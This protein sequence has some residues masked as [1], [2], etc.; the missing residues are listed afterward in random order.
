MAQE[1]T[2][3]IIAEGKNIKLVTGQVDKL[4]KE[5]KNTGNSMKNAGKQ[6]DQFFNKQQ[7]G[8][9]GVANGTKSF[10]KMQ[11]TIGSGSSGLVGAYATLAANV[12]AATAMFNA[13][14][15]AARFDALTQG[16]EAMGNQSGATLSVMARGLKEITEGAISTEE[17][18][19]SAAL[20]ASGGFGAKE[21]GGLAKIAK[22]ASL[23]LGR[24]LGDA[25]DRL[26]RGAIKLEPEIL[27]ELGIMVRLDD[28]V[29]KYAA[30]LGKS[31]SSLTQMERRQAFMNEI[32]VQ[33]EQK[34]GGIANAVDTNPYD[35]LAGALADLSEK[36]LSFINNSGVT[37][38]IEIL[39]KNMFALAGA[40]TLV[41]STFAKQ[42]L[43]VL[44]EGGS[45]ALATAK[46]LKIASRAAAEQAK[47][48]VAGKRAALSDK[49]GGKVYK[50]LVKDLK[51]GT[52]STKEFEQAKK[53][54]RA[55]E[56]RLQSQLDSGRINGKKSRELKAGE[57]KD[58]LDLI[59]LTKQEIVAVQQLQLAQQGQGAAF[60]ASKTASAGARAQGTASGLLGEMSGKTGL[61]GIKAL[62][63]MLGKASKSARRFKLELMSANKVTSATGRVHI[64][65]LAKGLA[66]VKGF[67]FQAGLSAKLFGAAL[68]NAIPVIG[69]VIF[70]AGLIG[71]AISNAMKTP[72]TEALKKAQEN[73]RDV[74]DSLP[75]KVEAF[76]RAQ[77]LLSNPA[78]R[79]TQ[80]YSILSGTIDEAVKTMDDLLKKEKEVAKAEER[81]KNAKAEFSGFSGGAETDLGDL[82]GR[83]SA[84]G[85]AGQMTSFYEQEFSG[86]LKATNRFS[87]AQLDILGGLVNK[88]QFN[89]FSEIM[90]SG[91]FPDLEKDFDLAGLVA[92]GTSTEDI[93]NKMSEALRNTQ[94]SAKGVGPALVGLAEAFKT[95][96]IAFSKFFQTGVKKTPYDQIKKNMQEV[97]NNIN[98][99]RE[100]LGNEKTP[101]GQFK[102]MQM[103][104]AIGVGAALTGAGSMVGTVLGPEFRAAQDRAIKNGEIR[105]K[106]AAEL[107]VLESKEGDITKEV[108]DL[109]GKIAVATG[110]QENAEFAL[111]K[112]YTKNAQG[113]LTQL[114]ILQEQGL[115]TANIVKKEESRAKLLKATIMTGAA[116]GIQIDFQNNALEKQNDYLTNQITFWTTIAAKEPEGTERRAQLD[117]FI[118]GLQQKQQK[119]KENIMSVEERSFQ[120]T[121]ASLAIRTKELAAEKAIA[122]LLRQ[123]T[124]DMAIINEFE[125]QGMKDPLTKFKA[126]VQAAKD[127]KKF[128]VEEAN[129]KM[130]TLQAE[131]DVIK[132]R[133][134]LLALELEKEG[135]NDLAKKVRDSAG[136]LD[137][138]T[139]RQREVLQ[140]TADMAGIT[141]QASIIKSFQGALSES[142]TSQAIG[143]LAEVTGARASN[144]YDKAVKLAG[145]KAYDEA[146]AAGVSESTSQVLRD[147]AE[148]GAKDPGGAADKA[149][150][151]AGKLTG[152]DVFQGIQGG[153][154]ELAKLG[155][156]GELVQTA[157]NG[158][159]NIGVAFKALGESGGSAASK[160]A[161]GMAIVSE[162]SNIMAAH[163]K[164]KIAN[165]DREIEAE[166]KRDGKSKASLD[167]IKAMEKKKEQMARKAFEMSKK[168]QIASAIINT[169]GAV[170]G[171]LNYDPK[172]V[173]NIPLAIAVG[174]MGMAQIAM[175]Q[176]TSFQGSSSGGGAAAPQSI[177][178]GKR[179]TS[180]DVSKGATG[181]E[182]AFLRGERGIGSNANAF[183][184]GGAAGMRK[185]YAAGGEIMVGEKGPEILQPTS[186]GFNVIPNDKMGG[187]TTN[188]NFTINAV[189]AAGV[190]EVL[191]AQRAN[192][193]NM[194]REAAHEHGEE[195]I[196][197]VNTSSYGGG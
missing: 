73:L 41:A 43:P 131:T 87:E 129:I 102:E 176:K 145:D 123:Q 99:V 107:I 22:G 5:V 57:K 53:S 52:A 108:A 64:P 140:K 112:H 27:D 197:G 133:Y 20:G 16:L 61:G 115:T 181:G 72:E 144:A 183:T 62:P 91:L 106:L 121:K 187:G 75:G 168:M 172:G 71:G 81:K 119:N 167:K 195:F 54:L 174:A 147:N 182:P 186:N 169:A 152:A 171:A 134:E 193:I 179:N 69:Q 117:A 166:K 80:S 110:N 92:A 153:L 130:L 143:M 40:A 28:A 136:A 21:L 44:A 114:E 173:W 83:G 19:R 196:E 84:F 103:E 98:K 10:S 125:L 1:L 7:K 127:K 90:R 165:I 170:I 137:A 34:F 78:L 159:V 122:G 128:A 18:F 139:A 155:P 126:E 154:A 96:D 70:F 12:F 17:A 111:G 48:E 89:T 120:V 180:V 32:L 23:A 146:I 9:I 85:N 138:A 132:A 124:A 189:D 37:A 3:K 93:L 67:F 95:A 100:E 8:V 65:K 56:A 55:T 24:D 4:G 33:G 104:T 46:N 142:N 79:I 31:A 150:T 30:T 175:I 86:V 88:P 185:G 109:K 11:Q 74:L 151:N 60:I 39:S 68:L 101:E 35:R 76:E 105:A 158:I 163:S 156:E 51:D 135:K 50:K 38:F 178:V 116:S 162:I 77:L 14:R 45:R 190:E 13:L 148:A 63:E 58:K 188:A 194:I 164:A 161:A 15:G 177:S 29:E 6:Q 141:M 160:A 191:T 94:E 42:M 36:L 149:A 184:P 113:A 157:V 118:V 26:T 97:V 82:A 59:A 2:L 25:F 49:T 66:H 47:S 192:I